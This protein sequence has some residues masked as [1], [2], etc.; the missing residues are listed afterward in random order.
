[1]YAVEKIEAE[2]GQVADFEQPGLGCLGVACVAAMA[3]HPC[4]T[5]SIVMGCQLMGS[6][7]SLLESMDLA[8]T[9]VC[10]VAGV[11]AERTGCLGIAGC[12]AAVGMT[13]CPGVVCV[14]L[15]LTG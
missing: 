15:E 12:V 3:G 10:P 14:A 5:L 8:E 11:V 13:G 4:V 6:H 7:S 2:F 9:T 1:M